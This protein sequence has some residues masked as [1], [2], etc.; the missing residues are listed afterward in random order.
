M[1]SKNMVAIRAKEARSTRRSPFLRIFFALEHVWAASPVVTKV[2]D[3]QSHYTLWCNKTSY[4]D[5]QIFFHKITGGFPL[6]VWGEIVADRR[7]K[8]Q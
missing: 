1:R 6:H 8:K 7:W 2:S 4:I 3:R 5:S